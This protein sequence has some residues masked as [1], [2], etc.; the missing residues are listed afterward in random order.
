[1]P[2]R[3]RLACFAANAFITSGYQEYF[4]QFRDVRTFVHG[5]DTRFVRL[6]RCR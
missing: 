3:V 6:H 2:A 5:G 1:M 4:K